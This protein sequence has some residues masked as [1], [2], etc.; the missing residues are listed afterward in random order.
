MFPSHYFPDGYFAP[1]YWP[2]VGADSAAPTPEVF[3]LEGGYGF[4]MAIEAADGR[5]V[6]V[7]GADGRC[8]S[9]EG[10]G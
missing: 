7:Q 2:K 10:G 8:E 4:R 5:I 6:S 1:R 9:V 3:R